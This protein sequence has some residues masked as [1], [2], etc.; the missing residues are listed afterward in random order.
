VS[1]GVDNNILSE[2][3][4]PFIIKPFEQCFEVSRVTSSFEKPN[5]SRKVRKCENRREDKSDSHSGNK[6]GSMIGG[7][8]VDEEITPRSVVN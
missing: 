3:C 4:V 7:N 2:R 6:I 1:F 5:R 8:V